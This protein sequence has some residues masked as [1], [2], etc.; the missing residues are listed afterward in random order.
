MLARLKPGVTIQQAQAEI[1]VLYRQMQTALR[2]N[3][4]T[5][6]ELLPAG[7]GLARV[8]D[9]YGKPLVLLA[10][11]VGLLLL[12]ACINMASMLLSRSAERQKELAV[13]VGVGAGRGQ[14]V[15]QML[16]ESL[17]LS[18][19]GGVA[20]VA[21]AYCGVGVLVRIM[22]S[23]RAFERIDIEAHPD[24]HVVL[25]TAGIALLTGLLR[26]IGDTDP[27]TAGPGR[28]PSSPACVRWP[29]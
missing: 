28:R 10:V 9:Q 1:A 11:V 29:L 18:V 21:V 13:R 5:T 4:Q 26:P 14:L 20:G 15:G 16:T 17:L 8:R 23:S 27:A 7:A 6:I 25:F 19:A 2:I 24:L 12:L 3:S 22:A